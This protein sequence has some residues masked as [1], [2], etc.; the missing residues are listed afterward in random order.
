MVPAQ[1]ARVITTMTVRTTPAS[2]LEPAVTHVRAR[3]Q[4]EPARLIVLH[5]EGF[6]KAQAL[7]AQATSMAMAWTMPA[8]GLGRAVTRAVATF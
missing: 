6:G 3:A 4:I 2:S 8:S 5:S 1:Y 7:N